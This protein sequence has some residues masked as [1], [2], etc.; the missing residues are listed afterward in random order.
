MFPQSSPTS[1]WRFCEV[2]P[3]N[4]SVVRVDGQYESI[5]G[6]FSNRS[7]LFV[8]TTIGASHTGNITVLGAYCNGRTDLFGRG[9]FVGVLQRAIHTIQELPLGFLKNVLDFVYNLFRFWT[10][11]GLAGIPVEDYTNITKFLGLEINL[12]D[13]S[14]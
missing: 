8:D 6:H 13:T 10:V 5:S 2:V 3:F 1:K 9:H 11:N 14:K 12:E 7:R 4:H